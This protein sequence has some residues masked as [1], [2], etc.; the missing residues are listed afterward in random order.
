MTAAGLPQ[1]ERRQADRPALA[2]VLVV[3]DSSAIRKI[4]GRALQAGGYRVVEAADGQQALDACRAAPPDI[5]ILDF[6]M[7]I[8]DGPTALRAMKA[9]AAM[10]SIPVL[11]LTA[12]TGGADVAIGLELGAQDYLRKPCEPAEL[13]ARVA[14]ALRISAQEQ[15]L[16]L[17]A[18][19]LDVLSTTDALTELGNRR[20]L[21]A[22]VTELTEELGSDTLL[23]AMIID[24]DHFKLVND[25]HGHPVGDVVL[26][27]IGRRLGEVVTGDDLAR[28]GGEEF[29]AIAVGLGDA[30]THALAERLRRVV[31]D[32]PIAVSASLTI[33]VTVSIGCASGWLDRFDEVL[34]AADEALYEAK[35]TGRNRVVLRAAG[36]AKAPSTIPH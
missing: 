30:D 7:P 6:D 15:E 13:T 16:T 21:E 8:M 36:A 24:V 11:F 27:V 19:A 31:G 29:L 10:A 1:G 32:Q 12:R 22:R 9:D 14:S 4:L 35:D 5:V 3:D 18:R 28:W 20:R 26:K 2:T 25:T 33:D 34:A 23:T 17:R